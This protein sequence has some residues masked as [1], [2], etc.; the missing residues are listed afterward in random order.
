MVTGLFAGI[1]YTLL[2]VGINTPLADQ[3]GAW[4]PLVLLLSTI[5]ALGIGAILGS[6]FARIRMVELELARTVSVH[7]GA[8]QMPEADSPLGRVLGEYART[9]AEMRQNARVHAYAAGPALW[10]SLCALAATVFWGLSL[11]TGVVWVNYLAVVIELPTIVFLFFSITVLA[12]A[13]G[14]EHD[15]PGFAALTPHR[16]RR[17]E[18]RSA[19]LDE[20][21]A[22][23]PWLE[24]IARPP[25]EGGSGATAGQPWV[26]PTAAV[27]PA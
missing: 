9:S 12:L 14:W 24:E 11:T 3:D 10:G 21:I 2:L 22:H 19:T 6:D 5:L 15:V 27:K 20:T 23:L 18:Q 1:V 25:A 16:W 8:G 7:S 17:Y 26:E 13:I 4:V